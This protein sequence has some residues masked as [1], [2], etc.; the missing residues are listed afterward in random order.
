[1]T[2]YH[3]WWRRVWVSCRT[4][5]C[6]SRSIG[7]SK[8]CLQNTKKTN[9]RHSPTVGTNESTSGIIVKSISGTCGKP[10]NHKKSA[11]HHQTTGQHLSST[12][13]RSINYLT[14]LHRFQLYRGEAILETI[15]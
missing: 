11:R 2:E 15:D 5:E 14:E 8:E 6:I 12:A 7:G 13:P 9:L 10:R 3:Q 1:M 4:F